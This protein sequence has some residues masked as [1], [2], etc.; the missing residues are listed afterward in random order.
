MT[1]H[2]LSHLLAA[3]GIGLTC[4]HIT[5]YPF[6]LNLKLKNTI[7]YNLSEEII[8]YLS[9]PLSNALMAL[10]ALFIG[11]KNE[12]VI[13]FYYKN[14]ALFI[15][16]ILPIL[17][18][19]G[20]MIM[21]KTLN[22]RF[23]YNGGNRVMKAVSSI[24]LSILMLFFFCLLYVGKFN[25][26]MCI[27]S[28]FLLG[29]IFFSKEK[30]DTNLLKELLYA[31]RKN[32]ENKTKYAKLIGA[33][34]KTSYIEIAKKFCPHD[35]CFVFITDEESKIKEIKTKE[36]IINNLLKDIK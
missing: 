36:E 25:P 23:G 29:N 5:V 1:I 8:L 32:D 4:S 3:K 6:G 24:F 22:Y 15:I 14:I 35:K 19:D 17:P 10:I 12:W 2:E 16:N 20:G 26:S 9:G 21:K 11:L 13:S 33:D 28:A 31:R 27:F 7:I 18:L 30:Y 34:E